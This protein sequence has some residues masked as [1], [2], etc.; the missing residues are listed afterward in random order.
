[1]APGYGKEGSGP[2]T[3]YGI[4]I[5]IRGGYRLT[6]VYIGSKYTHNETDTPLTT[7]PR[8]LLLN[9]SP[10]GPQSTSS[11]ALQLDAVTSLVSRVSLP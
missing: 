4:E 1:M 10:D 7:S 5:L 2:G 6:D 8:R 3:R 9:D 11:F